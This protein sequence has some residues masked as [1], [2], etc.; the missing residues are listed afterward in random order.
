MKV[1]S[2]KISRI[3]KV[4]DKYSLDVL[5]VRLP[6]NVLYFSGY[7]PVNGLSVVVFPREGEPTLI[8]PVSETEYSEESWFK[9]IITYPLESLK[10][11]W[12]PYQHIK[13]ALEKLELEGRVGVELG[14]ETASITNVV[15]ELNYPSSPFYNLLREVVKGEIVDAT[16]AIYEMRMVKAPEEVELIRI[17]NEVLAFG[18]EE[19]REFLNEGVKEVELASVFE[20]AVHVKGTDYKGVKRVRGFAFVMSGANA[21]KAYYP[22]NVSTSHRIKRGETILLELNVHVDGYWADVTRTWFLGSPPQLIRDLHET[23]IEAQ[24]AVYKGFRSGMTAGEVDSIARKVVEEKG[25]SKYWPHRLGHGIGVR[26][27]EPPALHPAS[28][29]VMVKGIVHTVE[30]GF[31]G[32]D[33][34]IRLE[35]VV[36][37]LDKGVEVLT[38]YP[39]DL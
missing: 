6:E 25:F 21:S 35:D 4:M 18:L 26:L 22:Y 36:H 15:I 31:Y 5:I 10:E 29:E 39:K 28:K 8:L 17:A 19:A 13:E 27:H 12:N 20:K 2:E 24:E 14:F 34:G 3:K 30:P 9:N 23:L 7:W 33:F 37:D 1:S 38:R 16:Q 32:R 11:V